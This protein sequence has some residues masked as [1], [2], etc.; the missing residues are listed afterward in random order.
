MPTV[1]QQEA[2]RRLPAVHQLLDRKELSPYLKR[3]PRE[4]VAQTVRDTLTMK[5]REILDNLSFREEIT[6][7]ALIAQAIKTLHHLTEPQLRPILNATGIVLHTNLGR[8]ILS[9]DAVKAV[10]QVARSASNL[11]FQLHEGIRGSRYDHVE[12]LLCRLTGAEAAMVVNNNAA[13]VFH[14]LQTL[15]KGKDV[16]LSRGQLVEIGGSFRISE[17]M[18]ES[19]ARLVEVGTTN[20]TRIQDY[21]QAVTSETGMVLK[22]HTSNFRIIGFTQEVPREALTALARNHGIPFY[23]DLGSGVLYDLK[24]HGIGKEPTVQECIQAGV[25]LLSFSG[26]KLLG[27]PQAGIIVGKKEWLDRLKKNQLTRSL[28]VD[29]FTLAALEA[30]LR[31][32]LNPKEAA[33]KIPTL[34]Q[35]LRK[36]TEL[37]EAARQLAHTIQETTKEKLQI[38]MVSSHSEVGGG[39]MPEVELPTV[40]VAIRSHS[41]PVSQLVQRLRSAPKPVVGRTSQNWLLLDPRTLEENDFPTITE[42]FRYALQT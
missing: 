20:K 22:V 14:I 29:K 37:Q 4:W 34:R 39:S 33:Q 1:E 38:E 7:S 15:T 10:H 8:A 32:Y 5:R 31:H 13:A 30:T 3:L 36:K 41:I 35:I 26:D 6:E 16:I 40:C 11:E 12:A 17:I 18:Q 9:E 28:R 42:S 2:L 19:G 27:G 21:E 23:E 25:D 24:K